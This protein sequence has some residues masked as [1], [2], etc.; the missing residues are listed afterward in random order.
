M[1]KH[2]ISFIV[3]SLLISC[4]GNHYHDGKYK[5]TV[6]SNAAMTWVNDEEIEISGNE[7]YLK[8]KSSFGDEVYREFK[9]TCIQYPD[10]V[11]Y[12]G[13]DGITVV[14][15]FDKDGNFKYGEFVYEKVN[16]NQKV[17]PKK[18]ELKPLIRENDNG[19]I[20]FLPKENRQSTGNDADDF[21]ALFVEDKEYYPETLNLRLNGEVFTITLLSDNDKET[22]LC[23]GSRNNEGRIIDVNG[24]ETA[25]KIKEGMLY[26]KKQ[27]QWVKYL[28]QTCGM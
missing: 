24:N 21:A 28:D 14:V 25:F 4:S 3:L 11:E 1:A 10:R 16:P 8:S 23:S 19:A 20:T 12:K 7:M 18:V 2:T 22:F 9:T 13:K 6:F 5:A 15:R 26:R 17:D 27:G